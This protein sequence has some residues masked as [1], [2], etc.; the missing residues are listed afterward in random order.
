VSGSCFN[1]PSAWRDAVVVSPLRGWQR[2]WRSRGALAQRDG[3]QV[4][5]A[6][7]LS[8]AATGDLTC[9]APSGRDRDPDIVPSSD[10]SP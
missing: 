1:P 6:M 2:R 10:G 9:R 8:L 3:A 5:G 7:V 4:A